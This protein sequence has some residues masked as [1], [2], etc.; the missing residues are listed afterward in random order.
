MT[1]R[2]N[3]NWLRMWRKDQTDDFHQLA[4]NPLLAR[5][6]RSQPLK[7]PC[8]IFAPLC[9]KS[10]DLLWLAQLGNEVIGVELSPVAAKAFFRENG[11]VPSKNKRGKFTIYEGGRIRI[12]CG[13]FFRLTAAELGDIDVVYDRAALTALPEDLRTQYVAQL[14]TIVPPTCTIFLLTTADAEPVEAG[15]PAAASSDDVDEEICALY[16]QHFEIDMAHMEPGLAREA[17]HPS[18][19]LSDVEHKVYRLTPRT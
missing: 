4:V 10:L 8:R 5:F 6:W 11:L 15:T 7:T 16:A 1:D 13:D 18:G 2:D 14:R 19:P 3:E 12:L 9:G 17:G